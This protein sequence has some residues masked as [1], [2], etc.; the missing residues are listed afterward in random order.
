MSSVFVRKPIY[1]FEGNNRQEAVESLRDYFA[2]FRGSWFERL[3]DR[4]EPY[5]ITARDIVAVSTLSV[6]IPPGTAIWLLGE[7]K[8]QVTARLEKIPPERAIWGQDADLSKGGDAWELWDLV[9]QNAWP[10]DGGATGMGTTKTSKLLAA[11]R[12]NLVPIHD[13]H[14]RRGLFGGRGPLNYWEPW[15]ELHQSAQGE[16][17]RNAAERVGAEAEV[18]DQVSVLRIIDIVIWRW[19]DRHLPRA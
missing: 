8:E 4:G 18:S 11:K 5:S 6:D 9:Q 13:D 1:F 7:G 2:R 3:V 15:Q 16:R 10:R 19:V 12:P 14:I 17:L